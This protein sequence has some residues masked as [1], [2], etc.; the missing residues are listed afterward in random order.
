M[1]PLEGI[2]HQIAREARAAANCAIP[3]WAYSVV[4]PVEGFHGE[5]KQGFHIRSHPVRAKSE[6]LVTI[7]TDLLNIET[8]R[9]TLHFYLRNE[10]E[11]F[12]IGVGKVRVLDVPKGLVLFAGD[13]RDGVRIGHGDAGSLAYND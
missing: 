1:T 2:A 6:E 5:I 11:P 12:I 4:V 13:E 10:I 3:G 9:A 8:E 7:D